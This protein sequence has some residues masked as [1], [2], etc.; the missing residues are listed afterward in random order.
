[1]EEKQRRVRGR[2]NKSHSGDVGGEPV[3]PGPRGLLQAIQG[4][5]EATDM[6]RARGINKTRGLLI[7]DHLFQG[8]MQEC[9][10]HIKLPYGPRAGDSNVQNETDRS[11]LDNRAE[12]LLVV[13]AGALGVPTNNPSG[14]VAREGAIRGNFSRKIHLPVT[15]LARGGRGTSDQV[16]LSTKAWYSA[17][18]AAR[19]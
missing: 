14:L 5:V 7:V 16:L 8:A 10:L 2:G 18:M 3:V 4:L 11:R 13:D 6:A 1:V 15:T 17:D 12:S 19:H 9:V